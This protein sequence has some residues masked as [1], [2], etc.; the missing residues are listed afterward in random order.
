[1]ISLKKSQKNSKNKI[2]V[3]IGPTAS[4]KSTFGVRLAKKLNG[5][6]VSADSRQVYKGLNLASG[7]I[8]ASEMAGIPHHCLDLVST[9]TI[10]SA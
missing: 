9:K 10:F 3:V 5:E 2:I 7:K 6:I 8:T 1:M 4:G